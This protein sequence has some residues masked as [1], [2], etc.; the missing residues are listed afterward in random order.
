M[1]NFK[2]SKESGQLLI[3]LLLAIAAAAVI[4]MLGSQLLMVSLRSGKSSSERDAAVGLAKETFEAV[5]AAAGEKWQNL[6]NLTKG[7]AAYYPQKPAGKWAIVSGTENVTVGEIVFGRSFTVQNVC[8][9]NSSRNITGITDSAGA[10]TACVASGGSN[11]PST[12]RVTTAVSWGEDSISWSEYVTRWRNLTCVQTDWS[13]GTGSG[14]T[15]CSV[16]TPVTTYGG[17]TN[18]DFGTAGSLKL[19]P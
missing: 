18:I 17:A 6:Y 4:I 19:A 16:T 14:T 12:Q 15:T 10:A 3:E 9:D 2:E 13:G 11:D 8:R 5:R 1:K 7:S